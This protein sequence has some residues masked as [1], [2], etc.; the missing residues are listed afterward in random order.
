M[1]AHKFVLLIIFMVFVSKSYGDYGATAL[2]IICD[3]DN[4]FF[5]IEPKILWNEEY[6]KFL[7]LNPKGIER[8]GKKTIYLM[9]KVTPPKFNKLC[10]LN[11]RTISIEAENSE[12]TPIIIKENNKEIISK[13]PRW[14]WG[15]YGP[16]YTLESKSK[17]NWTECCGHVDYGMACS[18][19]QHKE[20]TG[21]TKEEVKK[22]QDLQ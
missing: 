6:E 4:N 5:K 21:C 19:P 2:D 15:V 12:N 16:L 9:E 8:N 7:S 14:V 3:T 18:I 1:K 22:L 20:T 11:G 17:S 10:I 13:L